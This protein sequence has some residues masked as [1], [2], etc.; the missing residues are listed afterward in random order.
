MQK[1]TD[2]A[3]RHLRAILL[4]AAL[5]ACIFAIALVAG[6][7]ARKRLVE[8]VAVER[9]ARLEI[10]GGAH[11]VRIPLPAMAAASHTREP[12]PEP[13]PAR[14]TILPVE[15]ERRKLSGGGA[16]PVPHA[17]DGTAQALRG[18]GSDAEDARPAFPVFSPHPPVTDRSLL[19]ATEQK[20]VVDVDVAASG[21]VVSETLVKG[22]GNQLDQL[23]LDIVKTWHF[24]P[25]TVN[26]KPIASQAELIFP[27]NRSYP[28][29]V[30]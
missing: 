10:A 11:A 27:F 17:G 30:S 19:P 14:R 15:P 9:V 4:S 28:I 5:H 21:E 1:T 6:T 29:I 16:P 18:N 26:G 8:P 13:E 24:Q 22:M 7:V 3:K 2:P 23:V 25:A 12:A 20:I